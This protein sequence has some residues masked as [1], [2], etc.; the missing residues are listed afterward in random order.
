MPPNPKNNTFAL[1]SIIFSAGAWLAV[2]VW[3]CVGL[4]PIVSLCVT[5]LI[6]LIPIAWLAGIIC[7]HI[8]LHQLKTSGE[9]GRNLAIT[10]LV[11]GYVGLAM[12][13]LSA[14]AI[15][16]ILIYTNNGGSI[17]LPAQ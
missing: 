12:A 16:A 3:F 8:A 4:V 5:P 1:S 6:V 2:P 11:M 14:I 13:I 15:A 10:G 9:G 7:G 17:T